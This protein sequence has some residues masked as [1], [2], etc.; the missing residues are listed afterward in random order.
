MDSLLSIVE[1]INSVLWSSVLLFL[2]CGTGIYF[3]FKTRFIQIRKFG[4]SFKSVFGGITLKGKKADEDGMSSFQSLTTAIAAQV[5]TGN[6][7]GA[8]TAIALG[9]PG[10]IFWM[11]VSAFFGMATVYSEAVLSQKFKTKVD[12]E[13]TGGPAYYI[14]NGLKNKSLGKFLAGFFSISCVL[15]LGF[16]GNMVQAN[17]IADAFN[18][19]FGM[20]PIVVGIIVAILAGFIFIGG[21]GRIA[22]VTEKLVP[23]MAGFYIV[24]S[25]G[26]LVMNIGEFI[27]ALTS[28]VVGAFNPSAVVGGVVGVTIKQAV[29]YGVARGLFSNEAG[30]GSTPHAHA[31]AKVKHPGEQGV[32]AIIS[33]FIDT[34]VIL[35]LTAFVIITTGA[36]SATDGSGKALQGIQLTQEAF[37]R[38]LG[39]FGHTFIAICL[40]FF[41]F[42]TIVG[43]YF[44]GEL[45]IKYMFGK[46]GLT[47]YRILVLLFIVVGSTLKV[48]LVWELADMFNGFMVFP[49][50][51]ALLALSPVVISIMNE[52]E[53][54]KTSKK[55][56]NINL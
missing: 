41:A 7:A 24:F 30:M 17:S 31:V 39:G 51:V 28:I 15:A 54:F 53:L 49:N 38:G 13:V 21:M 44:F 46:K 35:N 4:E 56:K 29:R 27:P 36:L 11:W 14:S 12:G 43:W 6:L 37:A 16:M 8:A 5:G 48:N 1:S 50:L 32:V 25:L 3:T 20:N 26:I 40:L 52:Y 19:A 18:T 42:S 55:D 33:V 10:A 9:G 23:I 22:S 34:F 45:N 47:P 2:L